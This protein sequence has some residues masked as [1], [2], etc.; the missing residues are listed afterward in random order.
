MEFAP[1]PANSLW[2]HMGR[3]S[4][5]AEQP[6]GPGPRGC[7]ENGPAAA[8]LVGHSVQMCRR[9]SIRVELNISV[10]QSGDKNVGITILMAGERRRV[11]FEGHL[12]GLCVEREQHF[13]RLAFHP[14]LRIKTVSALLG[15]L[16]IES[17][18][19]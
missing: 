7:D 13:P 19:P 12:C 10:D 3:A 16:D 1:C 14:W 6:T 9:Q 4:N 8:W 5:A 11:R 2:I 15:K 17:A 18:V